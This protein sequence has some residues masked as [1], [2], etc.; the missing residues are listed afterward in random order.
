MSAKKHYES[1]DAQLD[2]KFRSRFGGVKRFCFHGGRSVR[3]LDGRC[4]AEDCKNRG[5]ENCL[6]SERIRDE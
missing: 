2:K 1:A 4:D 5:T 3:L 6:E